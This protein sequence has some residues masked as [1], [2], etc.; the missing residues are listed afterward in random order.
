MATLARGQV[1]YI[2][3]S[4]LHKNPAFTHMVTVSGPVKTVYI[5]AQVAVDKDGNIVGKGNI[6]AQTEQILKN[7]EA[8]LE[9]G[10]AKP[11]HLIHWSIYVAEGQDMRPAI[12]VGM[13]WLEGR[14]NPPMNNVMYVS[15]F[16][17]PDFLL[18]IEAVAVVPLEG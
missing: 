8:C 12:E 7:I 1:R 6:A 16:V 2:N 14:P 3:P 5:G 10:G 18:S 9:A 15:G 13:R 17:P 11:E 4:A